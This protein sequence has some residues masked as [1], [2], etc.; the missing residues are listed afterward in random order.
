MNYDE[1]LADADAY[2]RRADA[3]CTLTR[4]QHFSAWNDVM[5]AILKVWR[6]IENPTPSIDAYLLDEQSCQISS[7]SG[8]KRR[9]LSF[10]WRGSP[11]QEGEEEVE[12]QEEDE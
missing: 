2:K 4:W 8:L 6:Q 11:Q 1:E 5:A 12:R 3:A 7:R 9:N 10:L